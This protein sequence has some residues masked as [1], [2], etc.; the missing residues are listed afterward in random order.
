MFEANFLP[1]E[2]QATAPGG[3]GGGRARSTSPRAG[4]PPAPRQIPTFLQQK[5]AAPPHAPQWSTSRAGLGRRP[6]P[7]TGEPPVRY[8]LMNTSMLGV[9]TNL[10]ELLG[11]DYSI[12][13]F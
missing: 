7:S 5:P 1:F 13:H 2:P 9:S 8:L 6:P 3:A 11:P 4:S 10:L 12:F